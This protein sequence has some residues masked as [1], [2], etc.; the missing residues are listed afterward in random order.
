[1]TD[2]Y[3]LYEHCIKITKEQNIKRERYYKN[4][5][6][7]VK[8]ELF[9]KIIHDANNKI[10]ENLYEGFDYAVIYD[11][12]YNKLINELMD[13]LIYHFK[14]FNVMYKKKTE[15]Q[16]GFLEV[17]QDET[18][19]IIIVDWKHK[20]QSPEPT[21]IKNDIIYK[22]I[23]EL[24]SK[25]CIETTPNTDDLLTTSFD[26]FNNTSTECSENSNTDDSKIQ[27]CTKSTNTDTNNTNNTENTENTIMSKELEDLEEKI[28]N[29]S[30][31]S[32]DSDD[33]IINK[34][35]FEKIF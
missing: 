17:L 28:F 32:P 31:K 6:A 20:I 9:N 7:R 16:R 21:P 35:G 5:N 2:Y 25:K 33:N 11:G 4:R 15:N 14:P 27:V 26:D 10:K 19:Y 30:P 13:S 18:N 29:R 24:P 3:M 8:K 23:S 1:M 12:E 22:N 34:F